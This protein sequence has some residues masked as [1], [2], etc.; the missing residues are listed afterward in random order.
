MTY[1]IQN[2]WKEKN[3]DEKLRPYFSRRSELSAPEG[4]ILWG[5]RVV[6]PEPG[7][8]KL[9]DLLHEGHPGIVRMKTWQGSTCGGQELTNLSRPKYRDVKIARHKAPCQQWRRC[10]PGNGQI[11][12]GLEYMQIMQDLLWDPCF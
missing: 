3:N 1:F 6:I 10:T 11:A 2:G 7:R 12:H 8:E 9:L 5:S 4:C